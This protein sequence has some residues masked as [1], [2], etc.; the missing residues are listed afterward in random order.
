MA[1]E[2]KPFRCSIACAEWRDFSPRMSPSDQKHCPKVRVTQAAVKPQPGITEWPRLEGTSRIMNHQPPLHRQS[3]QPPHLILDQAAQ[4]P[5]QPGLEHLQGW[6]IHSLS[7]QPVPAPHYSHSKEPPPDIQPKSSLLQLRTI[8]PP[9]AGSTPTPQPSLH[10]GYKMMGVT[11]TDTALTAGR[12]CSPK[13][14]CTPPGTSA[15]VSTRFC[16]VPAALRHSVSSLRGP[17][18]NDTPNPYPLKEEQKERRRKS[19]ILFSQLP[20]E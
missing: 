3:H 20:F 14:L 19:C 7:G 5:I 9:P 2:K 1:S 18:A 4:G 15:A 13:H 17:G 8:S 16:S 10:T 12:P 6:G 11:V